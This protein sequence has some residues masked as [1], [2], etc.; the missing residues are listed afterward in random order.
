MPPSRQVKHERGEVSAMN[1]LQMLVIPLLLSITLLGCGTSRKE[2]P[3]AVSLTSTQGTSDT[4][5]SSSFPGTD[6]DAPHYGYPAGEADR[7]AVSRLVKAYYASAAAD[8]GTAACALIIST[9]ARSVAEDYGRPPGPPAIRGNSCHVVM[10]KL[11]RRIPHQPA[12]VL[13]KT[14]VTGVRIY[15]D[16]GFALLHSS[17]MAHGEVAVGREGKRWKLQWL[18]GR[19]VGPGHP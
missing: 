3:K 5:H 16:R 14:R 13:A 10:T 1:S 11:F 4:R 8:D 12:S 9:L 2:P 17:A 6:D 7:R 15:H 19:E 18:I